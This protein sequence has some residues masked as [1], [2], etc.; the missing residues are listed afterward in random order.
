MV[1]DGNDRC[2]LDTPELPAECPT[3]A[4]HPE[5]ARRRR[6]WAP[7][8]QPTSCPRH[9]E[10]GYALLPLRYHLHFIRVT[11]TVEFQGF[12]IKPDDMSFKQISNFLVRIEL[13]ITFFAAY[14]LIK[15]MREKL[16]ELIF[17]PSGPQ[18]L[19]LQ[20]D[21]IDCQILRG[22]SQYQNSARC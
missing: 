17:F 9:A 2:A 19:D 13:R 20:E 3:R 10:N 6:D 8:R 1:D 14:L 15:V 5:P 12:E 18:N 4:H 16:L 22:K 11:R 21:D 7:L